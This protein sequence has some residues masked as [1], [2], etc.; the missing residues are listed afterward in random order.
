[1]D[2]TQRL[3]VVG[4]GEIL[5]D[6]FGTSR[7]P[8]GAPANVAFHAEQLGCD[9]IV[10]SRVGADALGDELVGVVTGHGLELRYI[11]RDSIH[12]TGTVTVDTTRADHP[13]YTIHENVA[14]DYI[15]FNADWADLMA[16]ASA[17]CFGT[18][19]QRSPASRATI[20]RCIAA[21]RSALIVYDVN[22]RQTWY[23]RAWIERSLEAAHIVKLNIDEVAVLAPL[24]EIASSEPTAFAR[25]L[26]DR[27]GVD[28]VCITQAEQGCRLVTPDG[29][30]SIPGTPVDVVDSVGAG[31]AFT[32]AFIAARLW[33]WPAAARAAFANEVG[34]M[35]AS[36]AGAMPMVREA[37]AQLRA[38][39]ARD[40]SI[41]S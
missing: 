25:T 17:V 31:D 4:L 37:Y 34:A 33:N 35:V 14:W 13:T 21:A 6:C 9:G 22:L 20:H 29:V 18:L 5:W 15:E 8:G 24:L 28:T 1:M 10:C 41:G 7:R 19:A 32:A 27:H 36:R 40:T 26:Q 12:P 23:E 38:R 30:W 16:S 39:V 3:K 2:G 11:Q